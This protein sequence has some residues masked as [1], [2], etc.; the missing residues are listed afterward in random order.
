[1]DAIALLAQ[2]APIATPGGSADHLWSQL[3]QLGLAGIV[4]WWLQREVRDLRAE[5]KSVRDECD[6]TK[7]KLQ[8][9]RLS[10][11]KLVGAQYRE[12]LDNVMRVV[13]IGKRIASGHTLPSEP[14]PGGDRPPVSGEV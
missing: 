11:M 9:D 13:A 12:T 3:A 7:A 8:E 10:D 5:L 1:M 4:I 14:A 2:A 6:K